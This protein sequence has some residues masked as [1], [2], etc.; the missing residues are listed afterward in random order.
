MNRPVAYEVESGIARLR[1][2]RSSRRNALTREMLDFVL[3]SLRSAA[4]DPSL[5]VLIIEAEG[6]VFCAGMDL[7]EMEETASLID[8]EEVWLNDAQLYRDVVGALFEFP[9]PTVAVVAGPAVAGGVGLVAACDMAVATTAAK[10]ALP[11]PQR[12]ISAAIVTPML[13]HRVGASAAAHLLLS[14]ESWSAEDAR[15]WG[16]VHRVVEPTELGQAVTDLCRSVTR[17]APM[18]LRETKRFLHRCSA[19]KLKEQLNEAAL[20]S[21]RARSTHDAR[22]GLRAFQEKRQA[23]WDSH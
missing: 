10:F 2:A 3:R 21:G 23:H 22:E 19:K 16:L 1:L 7:A 20:V 11:E 17:G 15:H 14:G 18:V 8:A 5:T 13:F 6:P 9:L 12:G 4:D